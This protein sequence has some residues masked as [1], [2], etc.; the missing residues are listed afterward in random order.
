[1]AIRRFAAIDV[2]SFELEMGIYEIGP[3]IGVRQVDFVRHVIALG[4]DTYTT[5]KISYALV[6]EMISVLDDFTGIMKEYKVDAYRAY[7]TSAMR[8][9]SNSQIIL[10]QIKVRTGIDVKIIS[11]SEQ[12]FIGY[13]AIAA[14]DDMFNKVI[15]DGTAIVDVSFGSMQ[16]TLYDKGNIISTQNLSL[17]VLRI[18]ET[19]AKISMPREEK[20]AILGELVDNELAT[21]QKLYLKDQSVKCMI[22]IGETIMMLFRRI[23]AVTGTDPQKNFITKEDFRKAYAYILARTEDEI[24]EALGVDSEFASV[25]GPCIL[26]YSR[27]FE[28]LGAQTIWLP[29]TLLTDGIA[30]EYAED[31]GLIKLKHNFQDDILEASRNIAKRY[32]GI[33]RHIM[34]VEQNAVSI[35]DAMKKYHGLGERDR[36]LLE[37]SAI[38][39]NCGKFVSMRAPAA[40]TYDIISSSEIIGISHAERITVAKI[41]RNLEDFSYDETS[42]RIAKLTAMLRLANSLD[43]SH[44]QKVQDYK[45]KMSG[46]NALMITTNF[47][48]DMTLEFMSFEQHKQF[49]EEIFGIRPMLI[50]KKTL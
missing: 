23:A 45:F 30:A 34:N 9:A 26:I 38:L 15:K 28:L 3:K 4:K 11:N 42:M 36:L 46:D 44:R 22:G 33:N 47:S 39:H 29:G 21:Y 12:R 6:E 10:D 48:G 20:T 43:R 1:M 16:I 35:F 8:E 25:F 41:V 27:V 50:Q 19:L 13:K 49:F 5:G 7:A 18:R 32:R 31:N 14:K 17:G 2:G 24:E 40:C 37:L